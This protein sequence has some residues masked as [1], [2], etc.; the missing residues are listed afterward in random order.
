MVLNHSAYEQDMDDVRLCFCQYFRK[1]EFWPH[2]SRT[3]WPQ[4]QSFCKNVLHL[5]ATSKFSWL[6]HKSD[7]RDCHC[8]QVDILKRIRRIKFENRLA[9]VPY[10]LV[11]AQTVM[12]LLSIVYWRLMTNF[13]LHNLNAEWRF[14]RNFIDKGCAT[15][16]KSC[17]IKC[18]IFCNVFGN[19]TG[20]G[21]AYQNASGVLVLDHRV[22]TP[23]I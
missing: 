17:I 4:S 19:F 15:I 11:T 3:T 22:N 9:T 8:G 14:K 6:Y 16:G 2:L 1:I 21:G 5:S 10:P 7:L 13:G 20:L 18:K 23:P 12:S